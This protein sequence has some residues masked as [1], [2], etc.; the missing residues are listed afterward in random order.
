LLF[1]RCFEYYKKAIELDPN[2]AAP[3]HGLGHAYRQEGNLEGTFYCW[4]KALELNSMFSVALFDLASAYLEK[5]DKDKAYHMLRD[6]KKRY[7]HL[8][9]PLEREKLDTLLEKARR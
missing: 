9:P 7:Y 6:Y 2:Y 5:G 1:S 3:Y 8:I 4:E